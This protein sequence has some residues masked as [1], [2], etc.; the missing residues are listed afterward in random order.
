LPD[1][2]IRTERERDLCLENHRYLAAAQQVIAEDAQLA[3]SLGRGHADLSRGREFLHVSDAVQDFTSVINTQGLG[4]GHAFTA[5][6][7]NAN[8]NANTDVKVGDPRA[9][10]ET[11]AQDIMVSK[12]PRGETEKTAAHQAHDVIDMSKLQRRERVEKALDRHTEQEQDM[13]DEDAN[14]SGVNDQ[15]NETNP[16]V[17]Q[18]ETQKAWQAKDEP[19]VDWVNSSQSPISVILKQQD[20]V[21]QLSKNGT[22]NQMEAQA[23]LA[24]ISARIDQLIAEQRQLHCNWRRLRMEDQNRTQQNMGD[25]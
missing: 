23:V 25:Y 6:Q 9:L 21:L 19:Q 3:T 1:E 11:D 2:K 18:A 4:Q 14:F 24:Q 20:R 13:H 22:A 16:A 10:T 7:N 12:V 17:K 15:I 5:I 8:A